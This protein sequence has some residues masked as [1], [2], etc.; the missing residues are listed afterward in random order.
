MRKLIPALLCL[1]I[2]GPVRAQ[3]PTREGLRANL[4]KRIE[5]IIG[6]VDGVVGVSIR[7]L[8][9]GETITVNGDMVFTQ[10]SS[11]KLPI[12]VEL[13]RQAEEGDL[14]LDQTVSLSEEDITP[15]SGVLQ[16]LTPGRVTM[17]LRDVATLMVTVSDNSATNIIIDRVGME[18]VNGTMARLGLSQTKLQRKM[19]DLEAVVADRENL[20]T[21]NEQ[22]GL[23]RMLYEGE[24]LND[25]SRDEIFRILS[26]PKPGHIRRLLPSDVPIAHK[27]G[28]VPG[29]VVDVGIVFLPERP[30]I[31][32]AMANW[33]LDEDAGSLAIAEVS[34]VAYQ[35]F[36]RLASS[37]SYGHRK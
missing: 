5:S 6:G 31:V 22:A 29:V 7:D 34:L 24:I 13:F 20:S 12:L 15:G 10:A 25:T 4:G 18:N 9:G 37:N 21:P 3:P 35:Y 33:L 8:V 2:A 17:T 27:T 16:D 36:E 19:M 11:I 26:I 14:D 30:F 23:L 32:S 1:G 28:G